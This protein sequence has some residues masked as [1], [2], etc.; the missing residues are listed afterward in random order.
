MKGIGPVAIA[1]VV[2]F[3]LVGLVGLIGHTMFGATVER[4]ISAQET[5]VI[6]AI[7][8]L[9]I[10]KIGLPY[11]L[12][13]SFQQAFYD[14]SKNGGY[15]SILV[16]I[17]TYNNLP[18]WRKYDK[19][20]QPDYVANI[21]QATL[22][23]LNK[24][25]SQVKTLNIPHYTGVDILC[26]GGIL[27]Q[28][29]FNP[30][31][32][33]Y[34]SRLTLRGERIGDIAYSDECGPYGFCGLM[35]GGCSF[36]S[37]ACF[38]K[39]S[40]TVQYNVGWCYDEYYLNGDSESYKVTA[41]EVNN[42]A[43]IWASGEPYS[44]VSWAIECC[45][46]GT[47]TDG[48][49]SDSTEGQ[50]FHANNVF[51]LANKDK[52]DKYKASEE[53]VVKKFNLAWCG[54]KDRNCL[55]CHVDVKDTSKTKW[56]VCEG[57]WVPE[58]YGVVVVKAG[59][60]VGSFECGYDGQWIQPTNVFCPVDTVTLK[61]T[62]SGLISIET[63]LYK[64]Y[65]NPNTSQ[66]VKS[67]LFNMFRIARERFV[68]EDTIKSTIENVVST[69]EFTCESDNSTVRNRVSSA[70][71]SRFSDGDVYV[72]ITPVRVAIKPDCNSTV[73][74]AVEVKIKD[75]LPYLVYDGTTAYRNPELRFYVITSNDYSF[76]PI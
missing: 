23:N 54:N 68:E 10:V 18:V 12:E 49:N 75:Q 34:Y 64:A 9:E 5:E 13:Y 43:Y 19:T 26:G 15:Y 60:R 22:N 55:L 57:S 30:P 24:Y 61:A 76:Q 53:D 74:V 62:S 3:F 48:C 45:L 46:P 38:G 40:D 16:D 42:H 28:Y 29:E 73:A 6:R 56:Y 67:N 2:A 44:D 11:A 4:S 27:Y 36:Y 8:K 25:V 69:N 66:V 20:Y 35:R 33:C 52:I 72:Q 63:E 70:I 32:T 41:A 14:V 1:L 58:K 59:E 21:I 50:R 47:G 31:E 51:S 39:K 7:N 71:T 37:P 17:P 65:E